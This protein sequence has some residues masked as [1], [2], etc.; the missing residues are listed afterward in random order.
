LHSG[1][2][3]KPCVPTVNPACQPP[4][5]SA[6]T[7]TE[8]CEPAGAD[9]PVGCASTV[10]RVSGFSFMVL[11]GSSDLGVRLGFRESLWRRSL[12]EDFESPPLGEVVRLSPGPPLFERAT[13]TGQDPHRLGNAESSGVRFDFGSEAHWISYAARV[14]AN[15]TGW[16]SSQ[17]GSPFVPITRT[18]PI[19][20]RLIVQSFE[21]GC[22]GCS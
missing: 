12:A 16:D 9:N 22:L 4:F 17:I 14:S 2:H 15:S 3:R 21:P 8:K 18:P 7:E 11:S 13:T 6:L 10:V 5:H 19:S 1:P 20:K